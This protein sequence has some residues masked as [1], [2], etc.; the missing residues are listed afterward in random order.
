MVI[1]ERYLEM[2]N[3]GTYIHGY[4]ELPNGLKVHSIV[5]NACLIQYT[6]SITQG[7]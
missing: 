7:W 3:S 6:Y 1:T 2:C 5:A 4:E